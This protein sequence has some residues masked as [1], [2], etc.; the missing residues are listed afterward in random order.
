MSDQAVNGTEPLR[1]PLLERLVHYYHFVAQLLDD[2]QAEHVS[3]AR[4]ARYVDVDDTQIRK[5]LAAI[6]LRGAPRMG[7]RTREV[8]ARIREVLA[9]DKTCN[10]V[11]I[12]AGRLG[13]ALAQYPGFREYG[14]RV[15]ALFDADPGKAGQAVGGL[16]ILPPTALSDTIRDEN[17]SLAILTVPADAAQRIAETVTAAG[18]KAIWNF[19]PTSLDVPEGVVVRHEHISVGLGE[20][21]YHLQR[22]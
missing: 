16:P 4:I 6:Q 8:L 7:F 1:H 9:F 10:A 12:G 3:S 2:E 14:L 13:G 21:L 19:A 18:A 20:L 17:V 5:D 11:I 22:I 15:L